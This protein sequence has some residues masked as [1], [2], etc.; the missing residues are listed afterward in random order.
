MAEPA[1]KRARER[2]KPA[3]IAVGIASAAE[4]GWLVGGWPG[5]LAGVTGL[6]VALAA[7]FPRL[8]LPKDWPRRG[9]GEP[10]APE[11]MR[12]IFDDSGIGFAYVQ[13]NLIVESANRS[14]SRLL[15]LARR[16]R[17]AN[18]LDLFAEGDRP[19]LHQTLMAVAEDR[20]PLREHRA[21]PAKRPDEGLAVI[22][23]RIRRFDKLAVILR[24]STYQMRLEA[25]VLQATKM[26]A[27]GQLA[28]G[29]AHDFNNVLTAII[30]ICDL[31]L[32]RHTPGGQDHLDVDQIRQNAL[33]AANLVRQLLAF[34]RQQTLLPRVVN[35]TETLGDLGHL[36]RRLLG[37]GVRLRLIHGAELP[38]VR[39]DPSQLEQVIINLAVNARDAMPEGRGDLTISTQLIAGRDV[40]RLGHRVMPTIDFIAITVK[41]TGVG[42]P[43]GIIDHIFEP[44]FTTKPVGKGTGLGLATVYGIVKQTGGYIF[45]KSPPGEGATFT[46]YLPA[47]PPQV[48]PAPVPVPVIVHEQMGQGRVL[49]VEDE[50]MVRMVAARALTRNGYDVVSAESGEEALE[51][52]DGQSIDLLISDV[53]MPGMDGPTFV[54]AA[55]RRRPD[56]KVLFISGYAEEQI[57]DRVEIGSAALLRKPFTVNELNAAVRERLAA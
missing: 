15:G 1:A 5:L 21:I 53:V 22:V 14:F 33:R 37:E 49:L 19:A 35:V 2:A 57:R 10:A 51:L 29:L 6:S 56:I 24:D 54:A 26:Q 45:A 25:Q 44:F 46:I 12:E 52:L 3:L 38:A 20:S 16:A 4:V 43:P 34:S 9:F 23:V 47:L 32:M 50:P 8:S 39:V 40:A 17:G 36:L 18:L 7:L 48:A 28:G 31:A 55:R 27:V 42:I 30:G 13:E 11:F 41:D